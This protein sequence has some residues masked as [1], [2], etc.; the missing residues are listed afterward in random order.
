M[1]NNI[2]ILSGRA[3]GDTHP[4]NRKARSAAL[5]YVAH[6]EQ[7]GYKVHQEETNAIDGDLLVYMKLSHYRDL[8]ARRNYCL[9]AALRK[10]S[11]A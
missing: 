5:V 7:T 3:T 9:S 10:T 11:Q 4:K 8:R 6:N 1:A 2:H